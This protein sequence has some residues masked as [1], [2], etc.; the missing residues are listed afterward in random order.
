[1]GGYLPHGQD[2]GEVPGPSGA[3]IDEDTPAVAVRREAGVHIVRDGKGGGG[4]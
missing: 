4:F 3:E 1:M 2:P